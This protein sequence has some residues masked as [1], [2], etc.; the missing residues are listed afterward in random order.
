MPRRQPRWPSIGLTSCSPAPRAAHASTVERRSPAPP[1]RSRSS[2]VRQEFVQRRIEQADGDRQPRHDPEQLDEILRAA[3]AAAWPAPSRRPASSSARII[4]RTAAM[5]VGVEEH[6][7]G[8]A[9]ADAL[10]AELARGAR[11][12]AAFR[13][14]RAPSAGARCRPTPS[15]CRNRPTAPARSV[16][17]APTITSPVRAVDRD[18]VARRAPGAA[19]TRMRPA[20]AVDAEL[21]GAGDA[22]PAHAARDHGRVA[23]HAAARGQDARGRVHAVDVLR[24]GLDRAPGSPPRPWRRAPRPR[25]RRTRPCRDAA[26]GEAGRPARDHVALRLGIERRVQQLVERGGIDAQHRLG[27]RRSAPRCTMSTAIFSAACGGAL[28]VA[29]LQ[30]AELALLDGELDV[31]HVAVVALRAAARTVAELR[32]RPPASPLPSPAGSAVGASRRPWSGA[33]A[34]GC[35]RPRPRPAR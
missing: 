7:L 1:R 25:R 10:G 28:A 21:A 24:A 8:A 3:S 26:P 22:G 12:R 31:L 14:W 5:R 11:H 35:R 29:G 2:R 27:P 32:R 9:Q 20:P 15:A 4:S 18:D 33:A 13:R 30:H 34:C 23:G 16:G 17:T 6:V 19:A